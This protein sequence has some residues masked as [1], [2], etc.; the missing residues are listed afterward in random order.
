MSKQDLIDIDGVV[1]AESHGI[2]TVALVNGHTARATL[3]GRIRQ[4]R[5]N[6]VLG[7]AVKISFSPYDLTHGILVYRYSTR[8]ARAA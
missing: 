5:V 1:Q 4:N 6:V 3:S 7:D 2:Y 8:A